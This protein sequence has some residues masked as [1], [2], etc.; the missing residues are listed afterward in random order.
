MARWSWNGSVGFALR[1]TFFFVS[2]ENKGLMPNQIRKNGVSKMVHFLQRRV[3]PG[4]F[5]H[6]WHRTYGRKSVRRANESVE[7]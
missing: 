6:K 7:N 3:S 5:S 4:W 1:Q 2:A